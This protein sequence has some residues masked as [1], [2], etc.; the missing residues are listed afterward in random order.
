M[1]SLVKILIS[2]I[3]M[4]VV[5]YSLLY[6]L[7]LFVDTRTF[8]GIFIQSFFAATGGVIVY[9]IASLLFKLTEGLKLIKKLFRSRA[10]NK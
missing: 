6:C 10:E 4:G 9:F 5:V 3:F 2:C 7:D 1:N 8:M